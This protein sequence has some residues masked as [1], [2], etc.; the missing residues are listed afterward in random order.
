MPGVRGGVADLARFERYA[1]PMLA[2]KEF[3]IRK[4]IGWVLREISKRDPEWVAA[5]TAAQVREMSGV[6]FREAVRRLPP[7]QAERLRAERLRAGQQGRR[8]EPHRRD[9][10]CQLSESSFDLHR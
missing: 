5:W 7:A 1:I 6:T 3:F 9:G 2:E 8:G 10:L 4:A